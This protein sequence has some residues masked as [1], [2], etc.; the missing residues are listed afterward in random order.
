MET[1]T[2]LLNLL[3]Q[4]TIEKIFSDEFFISN[5]SSIIKIKDLKIDDIDLKNYQPQ[6]SLLLACISFRQT[7]LELAGLYMK[8][9]INHCIA[10]KRIPI[11]KFVK[12]YLTE[13]FWLSEEIIKIDDSLNLLNGL[14]AENKN[15]FTHLEINFMRSHYEYFR[16]HSEFIK[17][18]LLSEIAYIIDVHPSIK[19]SIDDPA[20][21]FWD[22][23]KWEM[24]YEFVL[25]KGFDKD[26]S[27][28]LFLMLNKFTFKKASDYREQF[29]QAFLKH[30]IVPI[31]VNPENKIKNENMLL[32][33]DPS[34][35]HQLK[36]LNQINSFQYNAEINAVI[37]EFS[38]E[39]FTKKVSS[40]FYF[41]IFHKMYSNVIALKDRLLMSGEIN[42]SAIY[43]MA[44]AML[45]LNSFNE[46]FL[47][48]DWV[49]ES[50]SLTSH[51]LN[52]FLYLKAEG[53]K[54][55][56]YEKMAERYYLQIRDKNKD[57][58]LLNKRLLSF[59]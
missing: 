58:R 13:N 16:N 47:L 56:G 39:E 36:G 3:S 27:K 43:L 50:I 17:A 21:K 9:F 20:L 30:Q 29:R 41:F 15:K 54:K 38:A 10:F 23:K 22:R 44:E 11:L 1:E 49:L 51:E 53:W 25:S 45:E 37:S 40:L 4:F 7:K 33:N 52:C 31:Q 24:C 34:A 19:M 2:I 14:I 26:V 46:L 55:M 57:F 12:K 28:A 42:V 8:I 59:E 32:K 18:D 35:F 48:I 5:E 6:L